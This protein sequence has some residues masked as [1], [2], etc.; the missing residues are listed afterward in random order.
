MW[1]SVH[2]PRVG[3]GGAC[4]AQAQAEMNAIIRDCD[5]QPMIGVPGPSTPG[6]GDW[7]TTGWRRDMTSE[8]RARSGD[9]CNA[10]IRD[11]TQ[12]LMP[13]TSG[14]RRLA[15]AEQRPHSSRVDAGAWVAPRQPRPT[16][17]KAGPCIDAPIDA[18]TGG[19]CTLDAGCISE[20]SVQEH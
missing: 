8:D 15:S 9:G 3:A 6:D 12:R 13:V 5:H 10:S 14:T 11:S 20:I 2:A 17:P 7:T 4:I 1:I 19:T 16:S 18:S